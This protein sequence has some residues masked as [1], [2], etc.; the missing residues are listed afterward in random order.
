MARAGNFP[1]SVKRLAWKRS[2]IKCEA[3]GLIYGLEEGMNG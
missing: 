3:V 2:L 1:K